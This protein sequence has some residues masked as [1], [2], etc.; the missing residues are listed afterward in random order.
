MASFYFFDSLTSTMDEARAKALEG[1][2]DESVVIAFQQSHGRGRRGRSW[3]SIPGNL[4]FTYITYLDI[5]LSQ[6][7]QLSLVACVGIGEELRLNLPPTSSLTYKWPN[8]LLLNTKKVSGILLETFHFPAEKKIGYLI[9][10][11]INLTTYPQ[12]TRYPATSFQNEGMYLCL[13]EVLHGIISSVQRYIV[14][15]RKEGFVPIH[16]LWMKEAANL[17]K[18]VTLDLQGKKQIGTFKGIDEEGALI[19]ATSQGIVKV[20]AGE[21]LR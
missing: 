14:L 4:Y 18:K 21:I 13:E 2:E 20:N 9:G 16:S 15:W 6:A 11:G 12:D 5:P 1:I 8:D 3:E 7:P 10:C 17:E 19:L